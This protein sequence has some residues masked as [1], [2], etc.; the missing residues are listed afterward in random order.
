[1]KQQG[2]DTALNSTVLIQ[3]ALWLAMFGAMVGSIRHVAWSFST[4]S[5]DIRWGYVQ[6]IATDM[7]IAALAFGIQ[8]RKRQRRKVWT[9]WVIM[10]VFAG[11]STYAN[12]LYGI[13]HLTDIGVGELARW[14]PFIMAAVLPFMVLSLAEVV[15]ED[16]QYTAQEAEKAERK[17]RRAEKH[18]EQSGLQGDTVQLTG[19]DI[20]KDDALDM[21]V[22]AVG[23][24]PE[25]PI[26]H[27]A[28]LIGKSRTTVYNYLDE[29]E[30]SGRV[31]RLDSGVFRVNGSKHGE[32]EAA[33]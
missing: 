17:R 8:L 23:E 24:N 29:L 27:L 25:I 22:T 31:K 4:L 26:T 5:G 1:M 7:G 30:Q 14:R 3:V 10:T 12:L 11:I 33:N 32:R 15:S 20:D 16:L 2:R 21:L 13:A 18:R 28:A 6:A 9:L 19:G